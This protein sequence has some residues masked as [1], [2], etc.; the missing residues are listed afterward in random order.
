MKTTYLLTFALL[1]ISLN[2]TAATSPQT[3]GQKL[4][5]LLPL[6]VTHGTSASGD[7][8]VIVG[9]F[10]DQDPSQ[11]EEIHIQVVGTDNTFTNAE[12][13]FTGEPIEGVIQDSSVKIRSSDVILSAEVQKVG[14]AVELMQGGR[15]LSC[16][17][18]K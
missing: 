18:A 6:G 8:K 16:L 14:I 17:I 11:V 7:C 3:L 4:S 10:F 2:V 1:L 12:L 5:E 13:F 9:K 15:S